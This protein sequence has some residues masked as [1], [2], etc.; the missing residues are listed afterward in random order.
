MYSRMTFLVYADSNQRDVALYPA[1]NVFTLHLTN[2]IRNVTKVDLVSA[3]VPNTLYNLTNGSNVIAINGTSNVSLNPGFY[4][5]CSLVSA[6]NSSLQVAAATAKMDYLSAE[7]RFMFYGSLTSVLPR[8]AEIA[9]I[10]GLPVGVASTSSTI[11]SNPVYANHTTYGTAA[12][13]VKSSVVVD[14][15]LNEHIWLDIAEFRTPTTLDAR[16]LVSSSNVRTTL[17]NTAA[18]SF[19]IIPLDVPS[20]SIKS[21]KEFTDYSMS[22]EFPSRLDSLERLTVRWLDRSGVPLV[23]N[24]LE[25]NSFTLRVHTVNVPIVPERPE[26][27]PAPVVDTERT[28]I[29]MGAIAALVLGLMLILMRRRQ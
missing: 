7:G 23:F 4:S 1:G 25:T 29:F 11:A 5:T 13:F 15:N 12:N 17:S 18:T 28:K 21:F 14:L 9:T 2:P 22:I 27:L 16:R 26:S 19:A 10:L 8:T 3:V 6:F 24:G 20:G